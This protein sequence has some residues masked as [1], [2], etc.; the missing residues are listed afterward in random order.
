MISFLIISSVLTILL[1]DYLIILIAR[2]ISISPVALSSLVILCVLF[3]HIFLLLVFG[4]HLVV[5]QNPQKSLFSK[6]TYLYIRGS[7]MHFLRILLLPCTGKIPISVNPIN[8]I[9][10]T[11]PITSG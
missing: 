2:T 10:P 7:F 5:L 8:P 9:N 1:M 3:L 4:R 11:N 6:L